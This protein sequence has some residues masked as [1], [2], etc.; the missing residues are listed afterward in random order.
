[1]SQFSPEYLAEIERGVAILTD[2]HETLSSVDRLLDHGVT[3]DSAG[4]VVVALGEAAA[5]VQ[6]CSGV[7]A[8]MPHDLDEAR[9]RLLNLTVRAGTAAACLP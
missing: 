7:D 8:I 3:P 9:E 1:M 6:A 2:C 5:A 4:D